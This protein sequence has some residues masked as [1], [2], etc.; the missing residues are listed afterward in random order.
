MSQFNVPAIWDSEKFNSFFPGSQVQMDWL[1]LFDDA[2]KMSARKIRLF[3]V[4]AQRTV[5]DRDW[6]FDAPWFAKPD[7]NG[8]IMN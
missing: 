4:L 7:F 6:L 3:M 1:R 5:I 2:N 8:G